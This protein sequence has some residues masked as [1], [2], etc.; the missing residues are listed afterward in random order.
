[1]SKKQSHTGATS[2]LKDFLAGGVAAAVSKTAVAPIERV[3]LLLQVQDVSTQIKP[4][5]KYKGIGDCFKRVYYEQGVKSFWN[6]NWANVLR[7]FPTQAF[8]FAF[9]DSF[10]RWLCPFDAKKEF[11]WFFA[12]NLA[13]GGA[14]GAAS[15]VFVY[16][17]DFVRTR[18]ASDIGRSAAEK[19]FNGIGDCLMKIFRSDGF[20]GLYRGFGV[21]VVG[22]IMYRAFFFGGYET[23]RP[24]LFPDGGHTR[25]QMFFKWWFAL[26]VTTIAGLLTYPYDTVRRRL[27]MQSGRSDMVYTGTIDCFRKIAAREGW[28]GFFKGAAS[29]ALRGTGCAILLVLY[30]EIEEYLY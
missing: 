10:K 19:Q 2:F 20:A 26:S 15:L 28:Q 5:D 21:S 24:L 16:P 3:K 22:I 4:E 25:R 7:Y 13:N 9:K 6:G 18:L 1:M 30:D 29:N 27:M 14:A 8:S 11:W 12:G 23:F 17:L